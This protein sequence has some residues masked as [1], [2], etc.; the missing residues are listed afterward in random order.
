MRNGLPIYDSNSGYQEAW[1]K[2]SVKATLQDRDS[3]IQ[4]LLKKTVTLKTILQLA[5]LTM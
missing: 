4:S 1:E 3:R 5:R 2:Q